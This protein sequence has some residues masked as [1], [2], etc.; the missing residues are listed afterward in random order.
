M[1]QPE[2]IAMIAM[3][4][5]TVAFAIDSMLPALPTIAA[6]LSPQ[7]PN[8]AQLILTSF[9]LG[10][11]L[12]TFIV[13]PLSDS[14]G[15]RPI[16]ILGTLLYCGGAVA[17]YFAPTLETM[18]LSRIVQG[19]GAAGPRVV[20]LALVRDL[21]KGRE[22]AR[23][24][25][26]A[27]MVFS[28]VP[29]VAPL[30]ASGIISAF[31][32]RSIF[33]TFILFSLASMAWLLIRQP[34][35]LSAEARR[36]FR[37]KPMWAALR[38]VLSY[39]T[40]LI[41]I[42]VQALIIGALFGTLSSAQSIF[43]ITFD[44]GASFPLW[45]ALVAVCAGS[46]SPTNA[47]LV[48]RMGM[49]YMITRT[50]VAQIVLSGSMLVLT[51]S[52]LLPEGLTFPAFVV[53]MIGVFAMAGLTLGNLNALALESVGHIAGMAASVSGAIATIVAVLLAAPLGL[54]F[55]GTYLPLVGGV[56]VMAVVAMGLMLLMPQ[57]KS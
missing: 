41:A 42:A 15:R 28:L 29:A 32:W 24:V 33:V 6:E 50:L 38:E 54:A 7:A 34:E 19:L 36:P 53:W 30:V 43:E 45:F 44:R 2:F 37:A 20:S 31:G 55:N 13:G 40:I 10:M 8:N 52:G 39:R 56:A 27:M 25:S 23:V 49:R 48:Q 51:V 57:D 17:A 4:S 14:Y 18:L 12:G 5:A 11:G 3:L 9:L 21:Y 26:F 1:G 35:T 46:A 47:M 22:M 16:I